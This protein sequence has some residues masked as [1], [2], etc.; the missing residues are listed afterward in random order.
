V[1]RLGPPSIILTCGCLSYAATATG[2]IGFALGSGRWNDRKSQLDLLRLEPDDHCVRKNTKHDRPKGTKGG[3]GDPSVKERQ[4]D[5][6]HRH[7]AIVVLVVPGLVR[8]QLPNKPFNPSK[9]WD[10]HPRHTIVV[11][12][13]IFSWRLCIPQWMTDTNFAKGVY[14][15][16]AER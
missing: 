2:W 6:L 5:V 11:V 14:P 1:F 3:N 13:L 4:K 9:Q 16:L 10:K 7:M 15:T 8:R 12:P